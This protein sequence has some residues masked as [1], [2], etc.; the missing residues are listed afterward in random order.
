MPNTPVD[1]DA[2]IKL[3][4]R[5]P[6]APLYGEK[7]TE[8]KKNMLKGLVLGLI[9]GILIGTGIG[10]SKIV[11]YLKWL[12]MGKTGNEMGWYSEFQYYKA[13]T[14]SA[15][16]AQKEYLAYLAAIEKKKPEWNEWSVPWMTEQWLN[17]DRAITYGRMA[18]LEE[19]NGRTAEADKS[20]LNAEN[21]ATAAGW[22]NPKRDHI[23]KAVATKEVEFKK[24]EES[25]QSGSRGFFSPSPH[26]TRHAGPHR[27]VR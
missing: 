20:W 16:K 11:P 17:Y 5:S 2:P 24:T 18:I 14:P 27:A 23:L 15:I 13:T 19:R 21:S 9:S 6:A 26:T 3:A 4:R 1:T 8:Q 22:K 12:N 10:Y 7:M 25:V